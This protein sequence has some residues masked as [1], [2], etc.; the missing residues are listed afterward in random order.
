MSLSYEI[1]N[2]ENGKTVLKAEHLRKIEKGITDIISENDAIYKDEDTRK[3][4]EKQRQEEHSRKMNEVSEVVSDIQK[5]YDSL[6]KI[7]IDENASANLQKQINSVNSQL[8]QNM[9]GLISPT[10]CNEFDFIDTIKKCNDDKILLRDKSYS[11]SSYHNLM[12]DDLNKLHILGE[13]R[14][15]IKFSSVP[16]D[17]Y[18]FLSNIKNIIFE[19][20]D[21]FGNYDGENGTSS[22]FGFYIAG[23]DEDLDSSITIKNCTFNNFN[24]TPILLTRYKKVTFDNCVFNNIFATGVFIKQSSNITI[25][26]CKF[27]GRGM[28]GIQEGNSGLVVSQSEKI[29]IKNCYF[30]NIEGTAT[31]TEG[32]NDVIYENNI[33]DTFAKDGIK[34]MAHYGSGINECKNIV[35][36]NNILKNF[37]DSRDDAGAYINL[38]CVKNAIISNN[39]VIGTSNE[40]HSR[41]VININ[42]WNGSSEG[43]RGSNIKINCNVSSNTV[44]HSIKIQ[45]QDDVIL[46][47]NKLE[48]NVYISDVNNISINDNKITNISNESNYR[49]YL[50]GCIGDLLINCNTFIDSTL[51]IENPL[52]SCII[53][54]N[55]IHGNIILNKIIDVNL[56]DN[57]IE[58]S[59]DV[60]AINIYT[61]NSAN[62]IKNRVKNGLHSIRMNIY[63]SNFVDICQNNFVDVQRNPVLLVSVNG[64]TKTVPSVRVENN[65]TYG[66]NTKDANIK[67][68]LYVSYSN[69]IVDNFIVTNNIINKSNSINN[70]EFNTLLHFNTGGTKAMNKLY[71]KNNIAN[72]GLLSQ[73]KLPEIGGII[74]Y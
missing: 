19:N 65:S 61:C 64:D 40:G 53:N 2:W 16:D 69:C 52:S 42:N 41:S 36:S 56:F 8:E 21:F 23:N 26:N 22:T 43:N 66:Y 67:G 31:K 55:F 11:I 44:C 59:E 35:I 72:N 27:T 71:Y 70:I 47:G 7:I 34:V 20:I 38:H 39:N 33:I 25:N 51:E 54:N 57:Y 45:N 1:T 17:Y 62:I 46:E 63:N 10:S 15:E 29:N 4:N 13:G 60:N 24:G 30:E 32:C 3:S 48:G 5:D 12:L 49:T 50:T 18:I 73:T 74:S 9:K 6:Q 14:T 28:L 37:V 58:C 68:F